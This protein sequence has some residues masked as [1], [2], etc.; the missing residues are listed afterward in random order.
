MKKYIH[1]LGKKIN[2]QKNKHTTILYK[3]IRKKKQ[4][5]VWK[6]HKRG[7]YFCMHAFS[8]FINNLKS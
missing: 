2:I 8:H 1:L 5:Q 4:K 3:V 7:K 6:I